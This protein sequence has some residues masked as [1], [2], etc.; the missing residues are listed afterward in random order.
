SRILTRGHAMNAVDAACCES[1]GI[2]GRAGGDERRPAP[3]LREVVP[4][5]EHRA[6]W[7]EI[8]STP[9]NVVAVDVDHDG[10][11]PRGRC[12]GP[13]A[14]LG[15]DLR[16]RPADGLERSGGGD[17]A[18]GVL[19]RWEICEGAVHVMGAPPGHAPEVRALG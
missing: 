2:L 8:A 11:T 14:K 4:G 10:L 15:S 5:V 6:T 1:A 3:L 19:Q 7:C 17:Q 13:R 18:E 9:G 16:E 12:G